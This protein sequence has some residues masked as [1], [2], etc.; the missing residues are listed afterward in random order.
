MANTQTSMPE[1]SQEIVFDEV[2]WTLLESAQK[3]G[4]SYTQVQ[5]VVKAIHGFS[6][7]ENFNDFYEKKLNTTQEKFKTMYARAFNVKRYLTEDDQIQ[8]QS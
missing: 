2:L 3:H 5:T 8:K 7:H 4:L 1:D 6:Y